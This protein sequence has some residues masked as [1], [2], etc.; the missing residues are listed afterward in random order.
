MDPRRRGSHWVET[1]RARK[2][3]TG[4]SAG[5]VMATIFWDQDG[6][7]LVDFLSAVSRPNVDRFTQLLRKLKSDIRNKRPDIDIKDI[8]IRHDNS[9]I[10]TSF[11]HGGWETCETGMDGDSSPAVQHWF[12]VIR[13]PPVRT[14]ETSSVA[15]YFTNNGELKTTVSLS[16]KNVD[17][18]LYR[19]GF[20]QCARQW[21]KCVLVNG[22]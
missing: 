13:L 8:T 18:E 2:F 22:N 6:I 1:F 19:A 14:T 10:H 20:Q 12:G 9:R 15:K 3:R 4:S 5:K 21:E 16:S 11:G 17:K 7:L